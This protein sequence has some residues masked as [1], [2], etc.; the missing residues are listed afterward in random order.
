MF[1]ALVSSVF[2]CFLLIFTFCICLTV[3]G[4]ITDTLSFKLRNCGGGYTSATPCRFGKQKHRIF[5]R[6]P[7]AGLSADERGAKPLS[8]DSHQSRVLRNPRRRNR[9][10]K[11]HYHRHLSSLF[12]RAA[13]EFSQRAKPRLRELALG[14]YSPAFG[15][16]TT[17]TYLLKGVFGFQSSAE[18]KKFF[19]Y[20]PTSYCT[21]FSFLPSFF[22]KIFFIF[23]KIA[24]FR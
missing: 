4:T 5:L 21:R 19:S 20:P 10:R 18:G 24:F 2:I 17:A 23:F 9:L 14:C 12:R 11:Y 22:I 15:Q 8:L 13:P 3:S 1:D 6:Y 16:A 7:D